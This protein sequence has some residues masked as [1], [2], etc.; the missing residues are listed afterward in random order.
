M[1]AVLDFPPGQSL[2]RGTLI[3]AGDLRV[4]MAATDTSGNPV[5]VDL[6]CN[7][8]TR[9][10]TYKV[11]SIGEVNPGGTRVLYKLHLRT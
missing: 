2:E 6:T 8:I 10:I 5:T 7:V 9:G 4:I 1:A 3:Q 11:L